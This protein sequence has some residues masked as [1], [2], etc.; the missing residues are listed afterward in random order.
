MKTNMGTV[1]RLIR[2][3]L[4]LAMGLLIY[5]DIVGGMLAFVFLAVISVFALTSL[6]GYCPFYALLGWNTFSHRR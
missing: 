2:L 1:D 5:Y 3:S 6:V 4:A